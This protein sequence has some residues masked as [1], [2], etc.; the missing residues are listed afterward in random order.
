MDHTDQS[1]M[2]ILRANAREPV[3]KI[4]KRLG[5]ARST[6]QDR[7]SRLE[8]SGKISGYTL[9]TSR[10]RNQTEVRAIVMI[11]IDSKQN[12]PTIIELKK[13]PSIIFLSA[14]NGEYD[15]IA[16]IMSTSTRDMDKALDEI[17]LIRGIVKIRSY[18][19]L[20]VKIDCR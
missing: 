16:E 17:G 19:L 3:T 13:I 7:I 14:I 6:V 5:I 11:S 20:S 15:Y 1:L 10:E 9:K 12:A 2:T 18:I 8:Q 4:A